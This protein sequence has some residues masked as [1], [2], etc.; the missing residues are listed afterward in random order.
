MMDLYP[1]VI[2]TDR[3]KRAERLL[4]CAEDDTFSFLYFFLRL[5]GRSYF[6]RG[7]TI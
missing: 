2:C 5:V 4:R 6:D 1:V 7:I 3:G